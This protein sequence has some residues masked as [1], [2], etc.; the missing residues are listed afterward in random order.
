MD[1]WTWDK[2]FEKTCV[3]GHSE[4][5]EFIWSNMKSNM[6][7]KRLLSTFISPSAE[8]LYLNF[9]QSH[10]NHNFCQKVYT[11]YVSWS[12]NI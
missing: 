12:E 4:F 1:Y 5:K 2:F 11:L 7:Q 9:W 8:K 10:F 3:G 6:T